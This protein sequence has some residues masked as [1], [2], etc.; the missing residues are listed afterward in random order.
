M[1]FIYKIVNS[2]NGKIYVGQTKRTIDI[3]WKEHC[4]NINI[5]KERLP[6]YKALNKYGIEN[7]NVYQIEECPNNQLDE[8]EIYWI[9][10]L[11]SFG[12]NGYNC[13]KGGAGS[14]MITTYDEDIEDILIR[15][16]NGEQLTKLC[17]EYSHDYVCIRRE[18][19]KKGVVIDTHAGPKKLSKKVSAFDPKTNQ[20]I[21]TYDSISEAA[22]NI[23]EEG[24]NYRAIANH[25]SRYK[26]TNTVSHG[27]LWRTE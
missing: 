8:R 13:S 3:R 7:F 24:R 20:L 17:E 21:N 26:N 10:E 9:R 2:L 11:K 22:R 4:K 23:C 14:N 5:Y 15:Y 1:G 18:L 25:I 27:F 16:Q 6:L 12:E 19:L